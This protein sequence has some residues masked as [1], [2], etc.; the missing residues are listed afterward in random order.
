MAFYR[1][2]KGSQVAHVFNGDII[3]QN[4]AYSN[5]NL[6]FVSFFAL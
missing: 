4:L 5:R 2:V 1:Y 6:L 3:Y